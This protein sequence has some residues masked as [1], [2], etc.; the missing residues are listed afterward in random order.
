MNAGSDELLPMAEKFQSIGGVVRAAKFAHHFRER[1]IGAKRYQ[2]FRR[3]ADTE[4]QV[5]P[6][7]KPVLD[8]AAYGF[9]GGGVGD[10]H[11]Q[12][13]RALATCA[14]TGRMRKLQRHL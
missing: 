3:P 10:I 5:A 2:E 6:V 7:A 9:G 13:R 4:D 12:C 1:A 8:G 14:G 11:V